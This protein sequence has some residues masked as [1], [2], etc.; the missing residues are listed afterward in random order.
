[1]D[2]LHNCGKEST[3]NSQNHTASEC[4]QLEKLIVRDRE[5]LCSLGL[6][7]LERTIFSREYETI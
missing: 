3:G 2:S 7:Y 4:F 6:K 5:K 1:M